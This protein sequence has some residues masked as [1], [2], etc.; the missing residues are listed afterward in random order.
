LAG[1]RE[2][3]KTY[4]RQKKDVTAVMFQKEENIFWTHILNSEFS[5]IFGK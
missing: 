2:G 4:C 1:W 5:E 3:D